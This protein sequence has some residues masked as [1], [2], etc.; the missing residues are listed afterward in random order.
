MKACLHNMFSRMV[1]TKFLNSLPA[2]SLV[3]PS[4]WKTPP[5]PTTL[6]RFSQPAGQIIHYYI[7]LAAL[8]GRSGQTAALKLQYHEINRILFKSAVVFLI[9]F[10]YKETRDGWPLLTVETEVAGNS[11]RSHM[12]VVLSWLVCWACSAGT[13]DFC[14][15]LA[16]LVGPE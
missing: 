4:L 6:R 2:I 8:F 5:P 7:F 9:R 12:K 11:K 3:A 15:A 10:T 13:R 14:S 16:A 1:F